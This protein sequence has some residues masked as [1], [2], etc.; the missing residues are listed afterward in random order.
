MRAVDTNTLVRLLARDDAEQTASADA[1]VAD[2]AWVSHLVLMEA[3]WVLAAVYELPAAKIATAIEMLLNHRS[4]SIQDADVV[5]AALGHFRK[6]PSLGFS[7]GLIL[8]VARKAG[9]LPLGTFD[10]KL[11]SLDG[12]QRL[13]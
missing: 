4:L 2:G 9:H 12:A 5:A 8:G 10:R 6:R 1:F 7:D 13:A 11:V 3:M